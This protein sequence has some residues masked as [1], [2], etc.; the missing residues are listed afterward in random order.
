MGLD[1]RRPARRA[2]SARRGRR[3]GDGVAGTGAAVEAEPRARGRARP[4]PSAPTSDRAAELETQ[5]DARSAAPSADARATHIDRRASARVAFTE[6]HRRCR[7]GG[8]RLLRHRR[9]R[10]AEPRS[11][12]SSARRAAGERRRGRRSETSAGPDRRVAGLPPI[13][14]DDEDVYTSASRPRVDAAP[15]DADFPIDEPAAPPPRPMPPAPPR[16]TGPAIIRRATPVAVPLANYAPQPAPVQDDSPFAENTRV[17]DSTRWR[18]SAGRR[19]LEGADRAAAVRA[20]RDRAAGAD[21]RGRLRRHRDRCGRDETERRADAAARRGARATRRAAPPRTSC[22]ARRRRRSRR[23]VDAEA[24]VRSGDRGR[25]QHPGR[26]GGRGRLLRCRRRGR[27]RGRSRDRR[28]DPRRRPR[29]RRTAPTSSRSGRRRRTCR[30]DAALDSIGDADDDARATIEHVASTT[31]CR[32]KTRRAGAAPTRLD[33][34]R[35]RTP[36]RVRRSISMSASRSTSRPAARARGRDG[37]RRSDAH[38][39]RAR[40]RRCRRAA[41]AGPTWPRVTTRPPRRVRRHAATP[42]ESAVDDPRIDGSSL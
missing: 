26:A 8:D 28:D 42:R 38:A 4:R 25:R 41:D 15:D 12:T 5:L 9:R 2:R 21:R 34:Q 18:S 30:L 14:E 19:A 33:V 39:L 6:G 36:I 40:C 24:R 32:K 3:A 37:V 29:R 35:A 7:S 22:A 11:A 23:P 1:V 10:A 17:A 13:D 20:P 16:R 27:R 31:C